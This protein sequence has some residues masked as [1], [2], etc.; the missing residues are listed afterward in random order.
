MVRDIRMEARPRRAARRGIL[1]PLPI[2]TRVVSSYI[3]HIHSLNDKI[4][5]GDTNVR[6]ETQRFVVRRGTWR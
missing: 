1:P 4:A 2:L 3:S 6:L 5:E